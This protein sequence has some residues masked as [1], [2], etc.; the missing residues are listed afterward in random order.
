NLVVLR[1]ANSRSGGLRSG[2]PRRL[3]QFWDSSVPADVER[4]LVHNSKLCGQ[5]GYS[6]VLYT[7]DSAR[8]FLKSNGFLPEVLTAFDAAPHPVIKADIFRL[9]EISVNGGFYLDADM[10]IRE[11]FF[12]FVP[13]GACTFFK[14]SLDNR[15]NICNW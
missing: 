1:Y 9:A 3:V 12:D 15:K 6:Y 7:E 10:I 14:W 5:N 13:E 4:L 2:Y 11:S 8:V